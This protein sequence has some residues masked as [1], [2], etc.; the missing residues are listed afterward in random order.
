MSPDT[1]PKRIFFCILIIILVFGAMG[2]T[3]VKYEWCPDDKLP[4]HIHEKE[5]GVVKGTIVKV[6]F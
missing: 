5:T 6:S 3:S 4:L 1:L 2:C